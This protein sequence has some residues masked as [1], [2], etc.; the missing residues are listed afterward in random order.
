MAAIR[1]TAGTELV[2]Q[3]LRI[4][5][6]RL[7]ARTE[8]A[9]VLADVQADYA[10]LRAAEDQ[11]QQDFDKRIALSNELHL[12]DHEVLVEA[13]EVHTRAL[14]KVKNDRSDPRY[15]AVFQETPSQALRS[16]AREEQ[17]RYGR[18]MLSGIAAEPDFA[19]IPVADLTAALDAFEACHRSRETQFAIEASSNA[20]RMSARASAIQTHNLAE[21]RLLAIYKGEK[22]LVKSFFYQAP[23]SEKT[24]EAS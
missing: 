7:S 18:G 9:A 21:H 23:K 20:K 4:L 5:M 6:L 17:L 11:H 1:T 10:A 14:L 13:N 3:H 19:S 12:L 16:I 24:P 22:V 8:A 2:L 15:L